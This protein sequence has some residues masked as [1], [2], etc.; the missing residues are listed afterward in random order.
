MS[1]IVR[2]IHLISKKMSRLVVVEACEVH[3]CEEKQMVLLEWG[4]FLLGFGWWPWCAL[5]S[6]SGFAF[7]LGGLS[8][9]SK[10]E[11]PRFVELM[12]ELSKTN[13]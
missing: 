2:R 8:F 9:S 7:V 5:P 1:D 4:S 11:R 10:K 13:S 3:S 12:V 6:V